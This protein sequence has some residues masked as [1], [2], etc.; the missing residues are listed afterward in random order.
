[1][2]Y[3][4]ASLRHPRSV[5]LSTLITA[6]TRDHRRHLPE[7][8]GE[9]IIAVGSYRLDPKTN[10]RRSGVRGVRT[11]GRTNGIGTFL[12]KHGCASRAATAS[13][14]SPFEC[15]WKQTTMQAVINKSNTKVH[16][17][18]G[19]GVVSFEDGVRVTILTSAT[20][21]GRSATRR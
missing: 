8:Y 14:A 7:S 1:M 12:P 16:S 10:P 2:G 18:V 5:D 4:V 13:A 21:S 11:T 9:E 20:S 6:T 17:K 3:L 19:T 15:W